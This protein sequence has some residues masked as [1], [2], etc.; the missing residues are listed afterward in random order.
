M[1]VPDI[2]LTKIYWYLWRHKMKKLRKEYRNKIF[3]IFHHDTFQYLIF[4]AHF[5]DK[6]VSV[7]TL[8]GFRLNYRLLRFSLTS[9]YYINSFIKLPD[10]FADRIPLPRRYTTQWKSINDATNIYTT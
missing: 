4:N 7:N 1:P 3:I 5:N 9:Q 10:W 6:K 2:V 8:H